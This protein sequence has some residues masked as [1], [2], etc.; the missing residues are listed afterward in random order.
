MD[1]YKPTPAPKPSATLPDN[2]HP[3]NTIPQ[4]KHPIIR[5]PVLSKIFFH[6]GKIQGI[7][8]IVIKCQTNRKTLDNKGRKIFAI[9]SPQFLCIPLDQF[10]VDIFLVPFQIFFKFFFSVCVYILKAIIFK[11]VNIKTNILF[12]C[13]SKNCFSKSIIRL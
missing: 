5:M 9:V 3:T 13:H 11:N 8:I 7:E 12:L 1:L 10:F 6:S 4:A 2:N